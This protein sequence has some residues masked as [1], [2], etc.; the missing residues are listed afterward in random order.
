MKFNETAE[1]D[2]T[3]PLNYT[4]PEN[5]DKEDD[6]DEDR[7]KMD[8]VSP[9]EVANS[10]LVKFKK[11]TTEA[12][13]EWINVIENPYG[14]IVSMNFGLT[15]EEAGDLKTPSGL[16]V[17]DSYLQT[18]KVQEIE[19]KET[20][21]SS[22][23]AILNDELTNVGLNKKKKLDETKPLSKSFPSY[24]DFMHLKSYSMKEAEAKPLNEA[25]WCGTKPEGEKSNSSIQS[26]KEA[27]KPYKKELQPPFPE[28]LKPIEPKDPDETVAVKEEVK[29]KNNMAAFYKDH[30]T[31]KIW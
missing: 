16:M 24:K 17:S 22:T 26:R 21:M 5:D 27:L 18:I 8:K 4:G 19:K 1:M 11:Q 10:P 7:H 20:P 12:L 23:K 3:D 9:K 2:D 13:D 28:A 15:K 31:K 25:A 6:E 29:P 14:D 30:L